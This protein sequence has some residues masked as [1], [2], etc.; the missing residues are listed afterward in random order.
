MP[1]Q[2]IKSLIAN[3]CPITHETLSNKGFDKAWL[4]VSKSVVYLI[5]GDDVCSQLRAHYHTKKTCIITNDD[6]SNLGDVIYIPLRYLPMN[7]S[8]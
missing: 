4:V 8:Q 3:R 6:V 2:A 5:I 7:L 1:Q